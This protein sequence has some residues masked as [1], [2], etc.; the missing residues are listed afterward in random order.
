MGAYVRETRALTQL[1]LF[2]NADADGSH[3]SKKRKRNQN[4][5]MREW[6]AKNPVR[7]RENNRNW[8]QANRERHLE[9]RRKW[10]AANRDRIRDRDLIRE[11]G[12]TLVEYNAMLESQG[13]LCLCGEPWGTTMD[14]P[15]VDHCHATGKVRAILHRR[16]NVWIGQRDPEILKRFRN[17]D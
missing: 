16:C 3:R 9:N 7:N 4:A 5:Y 12:I 2:H 11:Y 13:G 10:N 15:V 6:R 1:S 17:R 8:R 14:A